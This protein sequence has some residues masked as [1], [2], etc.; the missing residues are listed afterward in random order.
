M[1]KLA[2]MMMTV[3]MVLASCSKNNDGYTITGTI[4]GAQDGDTVYLAQMQGFFAFVP[5]DSTVVKG[6]KF[7]FKGS[8]E[9]ADLRFIV[10]SHDG[11][12]L[13]MAQIILENAPISVKIFKEEGKPAEVKGGQSQTLFSEYEAEINKMNEAITPVWEK[14]QDSTITAEEKA[15]LEEQLQAAQ[16]NQVKY[17][18]KFILDHN[19]FRYQ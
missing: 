14:S 17:M 4:E 3:L 15:K 18:K 1:K 11:Q 9:G 19:S 16:M 10:A 2:M 12:P 5:L 8:Q 13:G 7:E 6:G